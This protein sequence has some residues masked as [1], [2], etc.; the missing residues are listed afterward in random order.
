MRMSDTAS[1]KWAVR[2]NTKSLETAR[3]HRDEWTQWELD[4]I[5]DDDVCYVGGPSY[6]GGAT[7][8]LCKEI[9]RTWTAI[10]DMRHA[11][12]SELEKELDDYDG[13]LIPLP[14]V[15]REDEIEPVL[16]DDVKEKHK[17][18]YDTA[19]RKVCIGLTSCSMRTTEHEVG[20][21]EHQYELLSLYAMMG[22]MDDVE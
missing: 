17:R 12:K 1:G 22:L 5:M 9:G 2:T 3:K 11:I 14:R 21:E 19:L 16:P 6:P 8:A 15:I 7:K 10:K 18:W 20:S 4:R 13:P